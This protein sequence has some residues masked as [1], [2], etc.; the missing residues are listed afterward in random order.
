MDKEYSLKGD[1][2]TFNASTFLKTNET[3]GYIVSLRRY[4]FNVSSEILH[5][6]VTVLGLLI[7]TGDF[8]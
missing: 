1:D 4:H 6:L 8:G 3:P 2:S 7:S 5:P